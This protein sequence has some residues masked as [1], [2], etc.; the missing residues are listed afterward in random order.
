MWHVAME[1]NISTLQCGTWLW[2]DMLFNMPGGSTLQCATYMAH[3]WDNVQLARWQHP[4]I[5]HGSGIMTDN[6][7]GG[8]TCNVAVGC[9]MT[10]K[11]PA[12]WHVDVG[13]HPIE[14]AR[15]QHPAMWR[16]R[17]GWHVVEFARCQH[18]ALWHVA[19][20]WR[21]FSLQCGTWLWDDN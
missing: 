16:V 21:I 14:C 2:D 5:T 20:E 7:P 18:H 17:L 13:W 15:W 10:Y 3:V 1:W 4:A 8:I 12:M 19:L 6:L 11:H 9:G